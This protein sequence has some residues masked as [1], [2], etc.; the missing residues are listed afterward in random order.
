MKMNK[1]SVQKG[2][3]MSVA[4]VTKVVASSPH[5]WKEA[6]DEAIKRAAK[7]LR[8]ITGLEILEQKAMIEDGR[9]I[10]YRVTINIMF[11]LE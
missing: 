1:E 9:I 11:W 6:V 5:G 4:R 10:E 3:I 7:T 2:D 8:N